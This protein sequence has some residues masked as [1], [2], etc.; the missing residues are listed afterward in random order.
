MHSR[1]ISDKMLVFCLW[2]CSAFFAKGWLLQVSHKTFLQHHNSADCEVLWCRGVALVGFVNAGLRK[3]KAKARNQLT[4]TQYSQN[5]MLL[6]KQPRRPLL[7]SPSPSNA[8]SL[9][10]T[11]LRRTSSMSCTRSLG[12]SVS[13]SV[14]VQQCAHLHICGC[15]VGHRR[16]Q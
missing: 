16:P 10:W 15:V 2:H 13:H 7:L 3:S 4:R 14:T 6:P 8:G 12:R 1:S 11:S 5:L 9:A